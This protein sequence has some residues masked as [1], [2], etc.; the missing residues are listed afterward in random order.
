M[1][2][3][4]RCV[5]V[6]GDAQSRFEYEISCPSEQKT[7]DCGICNAAKV[8]SLVLDLFSFGLASALIGGACS[9]DGC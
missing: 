2:C 4:N 7:K 3:A 8:G 9:M 5:D 6:V 1:K